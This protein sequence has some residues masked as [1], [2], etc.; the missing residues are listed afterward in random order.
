[1]TV[2]LLFAVLMSG[3]EFQIGSYPTFDDCDT[4]AVKTLQTNK[5][6]VSVRCV[7]DEQLK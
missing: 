2:Y 5:D 3:D 7:L 6:I 1:M 4:A